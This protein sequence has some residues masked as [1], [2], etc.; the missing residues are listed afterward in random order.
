MKV[1]GLL[2]LEI[3]FQFKKSG[4]YFYDHVI[5]H[6]P[7]EPESHAEQDSALIL[8]VGWKMKELQPFFWRA[9]VKNLEK[10]ENEDDFEFLDGFNEGDFHR[11]LRSLA[12]S[13]AEF[14][15]E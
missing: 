11:T 15:G 2:F 5:K 10:K 12:P 6:V 3:K 9:V 8:F 1:K 13:E 4:S 7:F 14:Y